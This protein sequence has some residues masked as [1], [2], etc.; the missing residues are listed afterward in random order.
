MFDFSKI[1]G[2]EWDNGNIE[3]NWLK[4][5]V[6]WEECEEV[7]F[8]KNFV[9]FNDQKHSQEEERYLVFGK[10]DKNRLLSVAFAIRYN[11]IRIIT[12]RHQSRKERKQ[13]EQNQKNSKI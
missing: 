3:K 10:T 6:T 4:H 8:D 11:K 12:A 1:E 7:F 2:F 13:Y 5:E 9:I